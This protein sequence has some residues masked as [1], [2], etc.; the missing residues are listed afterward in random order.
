M[1]KINFDVVQ[2][3]A[4][5]IL[6]KNKTI[7]KDNIKYK[8]EKIGIFVRDFGTISQTQE[9]L[10]MNVGTLSQTRDL[11]R[12]MIKYF[13]IKTIFLDR[14]GTI[15]EEPSGPSIGDDVIDEISKLR[16]LPMPLLV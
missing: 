14:D 4:G 9:Y 10:R 2:T 7:K 12:L 13:S 15:V 1:P 8:L 5:F 6:F 3:N 11:V 16:L